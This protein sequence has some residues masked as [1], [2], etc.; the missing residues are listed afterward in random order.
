VPCWL[1]LSGPSLYAF[2]VPNLSKREKEL[3]RLAKD[4]LYEIMRLDFLPTHESLNMKVAKL[5][6]GTKIS[7]GINSFRNFA[8]LIFRW[9][10]KIRFESEQR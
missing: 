7:S 5:F 8:C 10:A 9:N 3:A 4:G 1:V 2:T 6:L